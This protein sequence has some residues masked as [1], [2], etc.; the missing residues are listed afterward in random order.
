MSEVQKR[1]ADVLRSRA[2]YEGDRRSERSPLRIGEMIEQ[3][4]SEAKLCKW[5]DNELHNPRGI[6]SGTL[7]MLK[8]RVQVLDAQSCLSSSPHQ[9]GLLDH[10][11]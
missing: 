9:T 6:I 1:L 10:R 4:F 11:R 3:K 2:F 8:T 7:L 5:L